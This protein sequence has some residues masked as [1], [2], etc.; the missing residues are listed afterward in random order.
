M[1]AGKIQCFVGVLLLLLSSQAAP[2]QSS[3]P[4]VVADSGSSSIGT[5]PAA[6]AGARTVM[7]GAIRDVDSV[8]DR[9]SLKVFGGPAYSIVYDARTRVFRNGEPISALDLGPEDHAS[10]E[11]TLDGSRVYA[12]AIHILSKLPE[13][14]CEGSV[15]SFNPRTRELKVNEATSGQTVALTVPL[16]TP[17]APVGQAALAAESG[18]PDLYHGMLVDAHFTGGGD[19]GRK[20]TRVDVLATQGSSYVF[21]G[22]LSFLDMPAR[23]MTILDPR[24]GQTYVVDFEPSRF[25]S[26]IQN[27][28]QDEKVRVTTIFDGRRYVATGLALQ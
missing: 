12:V 16:G 13:G 1:N 18:P 4:T 2:A 6:P 11:T 28:H 3:Q 22:S 15:L 20:A 24:D 27:L 14:E 23:R 19:G 9:F 17:I 10:V 26:I 7:G 8:R 25:P 5:L 21:S